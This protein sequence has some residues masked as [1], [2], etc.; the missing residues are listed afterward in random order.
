MLGEW[1]EKV[2]EP[3]LDKGTE[4]AQ[5]VNELTGERSELMKAMAQEQRHRPGPAEAR[6][7]EV[8]EESESS[9]STPSSS[10]GIYPDSPRDGGRPRV[11][12]HTLTQISW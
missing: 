9:I 11:W 12:P 1:L 3:L 6:E 7:K 5:L 2:E 10:P 8:D 4:L